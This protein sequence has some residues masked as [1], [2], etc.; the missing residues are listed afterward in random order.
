MLKI[1]NTKTRKLEEF[2]P[3]HNNLVNMYV[4]GPTVYS[5]IHIGNARPVIFFD[6]L[7]NYLKYLNYEVYYVSN[8]TDIDDKII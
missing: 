2:K 4:C 8:I 3:I 7:K 6:V 5:Y 1:Y